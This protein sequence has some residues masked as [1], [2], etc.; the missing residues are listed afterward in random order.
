MWVKGHNAVNSD[1]PDVIKYDSTL[2][3][4]AAEFFLSQK[5]VFTPH[6]QFQ[7]YNRAIPPQPFTYVLDFLFKKAIKPVGAY[8][9][10]NGIEIKGRLKHHDFLRADALAYFH[11]IHVLIVGE[12]LLSMFVHEGMWPIREDK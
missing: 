3:G 11:G 6:V 5:L 4:T 1:L 8:R 2:E 7:L 12:D 9:P 10:V